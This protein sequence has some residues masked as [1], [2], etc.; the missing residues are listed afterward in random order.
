MTVYKVVRKTAK[1][2]T[3]ASAVIT[4]EQY[5]LTYRVGKRTE[6]KPLPHDRGSGYGIC[7]FDA[8]VWA[9]RFTQIDYGVVAGLGGL[10][11]L[12]CEAVNAREPEV[13][14]ADPYFI[15]H[16]NEWHPLGGL[17]WPPGTLMAD[18]ITPRRVVYRT[19][20]T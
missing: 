13:E 7:V 5:A 8:L 3:Y 12:E 9:K 18:A 6:R 20:Q 11:V 16:Y 19:A 2:G 10:V 14:A 1:R 17:G 15:N 4:H